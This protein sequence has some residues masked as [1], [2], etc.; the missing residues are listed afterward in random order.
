MA[1]APADRHD[2]AMA[3]TGSSS[4]PGKTSKVPGARNFPTT[5]STA[6]CAA[7]LTVLLSVS[8]RR[9]ARPGNSDFPSKVAGQPA[10]LC[11]IVGA[12]A[13][14]QGRVQAIEVWNEQTS[15]RMATNRSTGTLRRSALPRLLGVKAADRGITGRLRRAHPTGLNDGSTAIDDLVYLQRMYA[16]VRSAARRRRRASSGY[17]NPLMPSSATPTPPSQLQNHPSFFFRDTMERYR[18]VMSPMATRASAFG[19]RV[20]L[21]IDAKP[22]GGYEYARDIGE[23]RAGQYIVQLLTR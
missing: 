4:S 6:Q 19:Q 17:N 13:A 12:L 10:D 8:R 21:G 5:S 16:A 22:V 11:T 14:L 9:L 15:V 7:A 1:I 3:S 18:A 23:G 20:R 2:Q